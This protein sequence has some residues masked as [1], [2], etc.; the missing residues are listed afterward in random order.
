MN[1]STSFDTPQINPDLILQTSDRPPAE[2]TVLLPHYEGEAYLPLAVQSVLEQNFR[3]IELW[4][5]D[6]ASRNTAW[7][8]TLKPWKH[9]PKLR[10]FRA[11]RNVGTYRLKRL[12]I[13]HIKS[14]FIGF[15]DADDISEPN[16]FGEQRRVM[17]RRN[18][19][20]MGTSYRVIDP[21]GTVIG[22]KRMPFSASFWARLGKTFVL[23]HPTMMVRR[24]V[25]EDIGSFDGNT[26][27]GADTDFLLRAAH[28]YRMGNTKKRLFRYREHPKSLTNASDTGFGSSVRETYGREMMMR[29]KARRRDPDNPKWRHPLPHDTQFTLEEISL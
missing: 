24:S 29:H 11:D 7:L 25:F 9:E 21:A 14:P 22:Q 20:I 5:L 15:H 6:D 18:L 26:R 3:D 17:I 27:V 13:D 2:I 1:I 8:E 23:H 12:C 16:R 28:E 4:V 19:D 10:V